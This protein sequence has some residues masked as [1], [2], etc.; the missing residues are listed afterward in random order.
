VLSF[1]TTHGHITDNTHKKEIMMTT[2]TW[3]APS[4]T[5]HNGPLSAQDR[6]GLPDSIFAFPKQRKMPLN[7]ADHV[8]NAVARFNQVEDVSDAERKQAWA[9]IEKAANH[10]D[11]ELSEES[12][13]EA[14]K[15]N[16]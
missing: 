10:W 8:R 13:Q 2:T 7:D 9:N 16:G 11:I 5:E 6:E 14:M 15:H 12:W 3:K 4:G 1:Y